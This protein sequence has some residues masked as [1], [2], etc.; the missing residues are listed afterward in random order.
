MRRGWVVERYRRASLRAKFAIHV[1]V[2]I[3]LLFA[4]LIPSVV[5]LQRQATLDRTRQR[6][7]QL[8]KVFAHASVQAVV[9]DDFL[10]L[11]HVVNSIASEHDVLYA[12]I[13]DPSGRLLVHSD[14]RELGRTYT[15][16]ISVRAARAERP[17]VQELQQDGRLAYDF[18][19]PI[20]VMNDW[21]A[22]ARIGLSLEREL[23]AIRGTRNAVLGLGL[24]ILVAGLGLAAWQA[25]NVTRPVGELLQGAREI[26]KGNLSHRILISDG[27]ELGQLA[28]AFNRMTESVDALIA[29]S[30]ELS[31]SLD[32][33]AV[34]RSV[35]AHAMELVKADLVTI[36]PFDRDRQEARVRVALGARTDHV[37]RIVV[38]PGRGLGGAVLL[39]G[40]PVVI[41]RYLEERGIVHDP[42]YDEVSLAEGI[43]SMAAVP[44]TLKG[45]IVGLLWVANRTGTAFTDEDI[46]TLGR[47][48][49]QAAIA[50]E[51]ARLYADTRLKTAR[52][53][54]LLRVSQAITSTLD[55]EQIVQAI[56]RVMGDLL[57]DIVV[58]FWVMLEGEKRLIPLGGA[59]AEMSD[60][61]ARLS[62]RPGEGLVGTV[63]ASRRPLVVD[64]LRD[65]AR[66][67][68]REVI[69]HEGLVSF[70]G[71]PLLRE[72]RVLGVLSIATRR[73]HRF[74]DDEVSLFASFAQ[75]AAI[76][77]E[78][79]RLYQELKTSHQDLLA[80]QEQ[81]VQKTRMAAIGEIAAAVAHEARNP[82]GALSNCVQMLRDNP[83]LSGEDAEL[84]DIVHNESQ[85]LN[86]IVSDFL[87]FGRP[88]PPHLEEVHVHEVIEATL[89]LL[90]R[91]ARCAPAIV[92][93]TKFD[94]DLP[95]I[96][97]DRDQLRQVFWNLFL[98][99]VQ[100]MRDQGELRVE[101]GR[102]DGRAHILVQDTGPGIPPTAR[103]RIF[104][105]FYTTRAA[106]TG[107]GLAIVRR[108]IEEHRGGIGVDDAVAVGTCFTLTLPL[109]PG[110][111]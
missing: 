26:T 57:D 79:A 14:M 45:D 36:A 62:F 85:R 103:A 78:N 16:P 55:P 29:T 105:P 37:T 22:V 107:L 95:V 23:G 32:P 96:R 71:L 46:E 40:Q 33:E 74:A 11:R 50:M 43:V 2:S 19:V 48:A 5:Y 90:R 77:L 110:A 97:A 52:L 12:M 88:R 63:A 24:L 65:D 13:L 47:M 89:A 81:L 80:A 53:E 73:F 86:E 83:Q 98:N 49:R 64:D 70:L 99:A 7:F 1:A 93:T 76:A 34:L 56:L 18:A 106:G 20:Y 44:I 28:R 59:G 27:D 67:A 10:I 39:S 41:E 68:W 9:A 35:A 92:F 102:E 3:T 100:A 94:P 61:E 42:F 60:V 4:V 101:T 58:R 38:T 54:S 108:I 111:A 72:E 66:V 84:L 51:N 69:D 17:L 91:D 104:E 8:T 25:R 109:D 87:S 21:R 6:G 75:Q 15:D 30:R 82:L 31:S